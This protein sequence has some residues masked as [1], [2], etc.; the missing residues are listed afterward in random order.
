MLEILSLLLVSNNEIYI[1][2]LYCGFVFSIFVWALTYS[3]LRRIGGAAAA[4]IFLFFSILNTTGTP[5]ALLLAN[6]KAQEAT[7]LAMEIIPDE[8]VFLWVQFLD[9]TRPMYVQLPW[10][11]EF[12]EQMQSLLQGR[13]DGENGAV[14]LKFEPSW[15]D[16]PPMLYAMPQPALPNKPEPPVTPHVFEREA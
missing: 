10:N 3:N 6:L 8:E 4:I 12:V 16:R 11:S 2:L 15:D 1:Y 14:I 7:V 5:R 13:E 9:E